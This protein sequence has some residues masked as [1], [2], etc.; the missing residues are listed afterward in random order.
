MY[1]SIKEQRVSAISDMLQQKMQAALGGDERA[2]TALLEAT[3]QIARRMIVRKIS[4]PDAAEDVVQEVLLAV[5]KARRT[6]E[7]RRPFM[8]W[9]AS[10]VHYKVNDWL[11]KHYSNRSAAHVPIDDVL[12][13]LCED[14]TEPDHSHEFIQEV[15]QHLT[16]G[17]KTVIEA[18]YGRE[19][20]VA[21]TAQA[22]Q[23][24]ESAV[25]VTAHRAYKKLREV[26]G[27]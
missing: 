7:P 20:S 14:V 11:R 9:L 2:Y 5:H 25:K 8:P 26:L 16:E 4:N 3:S 19:L 18:M 1:F 22:L 6:Y 21:E 27:A 10:I 17:Q 12:H 13:F 23:M 15:M 24:S